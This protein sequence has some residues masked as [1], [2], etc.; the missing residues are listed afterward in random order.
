MNKKMARYLTVLIV[1]DLE[2]HRDIS[3]GAC[4]MIENRLLNNKFE[5][6]EK[7]I[8]NFLTDK[9]QVREIV[10]RSDK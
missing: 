2:H 8:Y 5:E 7:Y 9:R 3:S 6:V 1:R 4:E 10:E